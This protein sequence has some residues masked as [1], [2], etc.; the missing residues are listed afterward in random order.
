[1]G[2]IVAHRQ[3]RQTW[4]NVQILWYRLT[5]AGRHLSGEDR[6][7]SAVHLAERRKN[8]IPFAAMTAIGLLGTLTWLFLVR[9]IP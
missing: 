3:F 4:V 9:G 7:E 6:I 5:A 8:C 2:L 1:M